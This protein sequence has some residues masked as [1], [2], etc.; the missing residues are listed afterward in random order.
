MGLYAITGAGSGIA[1]ATR[2]RLEHAGHTV[3]G[4]DLRNAEIEADLSTPEG[5]RHAIDAVLE[6][7]EGR[8]DG[9]LTAAGVGPPFDPATMVSVNWFGTSELLT[10]WRPALA[11][12]KDAQV[13]AISSNS[14]TTMPAVPDALVDACLAG[15]EARARTLALEAGDGHTY[16]ASKIAVARYVRRNAPTPA[17]AGSGIRLNA[18]APGATLTPLL[19]AGLDSPDYGPAIRAF[20][21]PTGGF[22]TPDDIAF[23]IEAMLIGAGARFMCGSLVFVDGGTDAQVRADDWPVTFPMPEGSTFG[24]D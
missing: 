10:A 21:V 12:S 9:A 16:A 2:K 20:P 8:L 23:W 13:V 6:Q 3:I 17:W 15:D 24:F 18:I 1:L 4:V 14:T 11:A 22:G 7:C 19:Q 5:R